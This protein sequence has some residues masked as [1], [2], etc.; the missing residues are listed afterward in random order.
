[1]NI[2]LDIIAPRSELIEDL[3]NTSNVIYN[4]TNRIITIIGTVIILLVILTVG[5]IKIKNKNENKQ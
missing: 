5:F 4:N 1:M 3:E 2:F